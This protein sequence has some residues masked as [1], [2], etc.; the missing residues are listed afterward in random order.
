VTQEVLLARHP[1]GQDQRRLLR[2]GIPCTSLG[3]HVS[4]ELKSLVDSMLAEQPEARPLPAQLV[5]A[6]ATLIGRIEGP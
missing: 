6:A 5:A 4:V 2:G 1:V 3:I